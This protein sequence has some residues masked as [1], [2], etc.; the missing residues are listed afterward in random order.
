LSE[1]RAFITIGT[2]SE[3]GSIVHAR[4]W[5]IAPDAAT[6]EDTAALMTASYG[7]PVEWV[8]DGTETPGAPQMM[9]FG[10]ES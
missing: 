6:L 2:A 3:D 5:M 4:I 1:R 8:S 9:F 7:D 10:P